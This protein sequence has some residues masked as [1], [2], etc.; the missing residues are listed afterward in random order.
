[1]TTLC[2][3]D[4]PA[5]AGPGPQCRNPGPHRSH[6]P[7]RRGWFR[8]LGTV[9]TPGTC[10]V[11]VSRDVHRPGVLE[12]EI[13]T[14]IADI[15]KRA[16]PIWPLQAVLVGGYGGSW[17]TGDELGPAYAPSALRALKAS[18]GAG[19]LVALRAGA[20]GLRETQRIARLMGA[21]SAGRACSGCRLSPTTWPLSPTAAV[22]RR[23]STVWSGAA[24]Q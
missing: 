23:S 12:V 19:V 15:L 22:A 18:M 20:C 2:P 16:R 24:K 8:E 14:T 3:A 17:L 1:M 4:G 9:E 13:G 10:L 11:T 5:P 7:P 6:R 21:E